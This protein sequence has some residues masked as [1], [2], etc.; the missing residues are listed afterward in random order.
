MEMLC[1]GC[2]G[3]A[4]ALYCSPHGAASRRGSLFALT[5]PVSLRAGPVAAL[6]LIAALAIAQRHFVMAN[7]DVSWLITVAEKWLDGARL[8]TDVFETNPPFAV[9][10][11]APAVLFARHAGIRPET[12][13][14]G[15]VLALAAFSVGLAGALL[16]DGLTGL[17]RDWLAPAAFAALTLLPAACF[18]EREHIALILFLPPLA[19]AIRRAQGA[20]ASMAM[21]CLTGVCAAGVLC[22]KPH[23]A[24]ALAGAVLPGALARRDWRLCFMREHWTAAALFCLYAGSAL[25]V[26][27]EFWSAMMPV[28]RLLYL[29]VRA[30]FNEMLDG[31]LALL[32]GESA[33]AAFLLAGSRPRALLDPR[34]IAAAAAIAG[35]LAAALI[36]GKGWP[37]HFYPALG[38]MVILLAGAGLAKPRSVV[39]LVCA[40]A[41]AA[42][43]WL[44]FNS[45][46]D[47]RALEAPLRALKQNPR[48]SAIAADF[49]AAFPAVRAVD[50][51][52]VSRSFS[53]WVPFH[54]AGLAGAKDFD[55]LLLPAYRAAVEN[56]RRGMAQDIIAGRPDI[57]MIERLPFDFLGWAREDAETAALLTCYR[58]AGVHRIGRPGEGAGFDIELYALDGRI[59]SSAGCQGQ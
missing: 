56:D 50:G 15:M 40:G 32:A 51:V 47:A 21:A 31:S 59:P 38:L 18:G 54:A 36:Q 25:A 17:Q 27:P 7:S 57:L 3:T 22:I 30:P 45:G 5:T 55:R 34:V 24:L 8:Y 46:L 49:A 9:W 26:Y 6:A 44:W 13:F 33:L 2:G 43:F 58:A 35:F 12:A 4:R 19:L 42:Q 48:V 10:L 14:D 23:F 28:A 20:G 29:P 16:R 1:A 52:W 39:A 53:R 41:F 11:H 37:Y